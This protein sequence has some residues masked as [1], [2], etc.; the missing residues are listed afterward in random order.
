M[1][2]IKIDT[3]NR[4]K[5][6]IRKMKTTNFLVIFLVLIL[7]MIIIQAIP[8]EGQF[9]EEQEPGNLIKSE[10]W[11]EIQN[12]IRGS[13]E[14]HPG[15]TPDSW[16][17]GFKRF[18]EGIDLFFTFDEVT[19]AKKHLHYAGLRLSEAKTMV[20][21]EK[22]AYAQRLMNDYEKNI[23]GSNEIVTKAQSIGK[24]VTKITELVALATF[25]HLG[26]LEDVYEKVP[27]QAKPAINKAKNSSMNGQKN[28]LENLAKEKPKKALEL[29]LQIAEKRLEKARLKAEKGETKE[30]EEL[31]G[32]YEKI[33]KRNRYFYGKLFE[34][35]DFET[36]EIY[37]KTSRHLEIL[38]EVHEKVPKEFKSGI[39]RAMNVSMK[40][41]E[42]V[43]DVLGE[44]K[45]KRTAKL[46]FNLTEKRFLKLK[47]KAEKGEDVD[48][49]ARGYKRGINKSLKMIEKSESVDK[50]G[51]INMVEKVS[52]ATSKHLKILE[53][54]Y[55]KVPAQ[56]KK[57]IE[58]A[59]NFS[60]K[61][62]KNALIALSKEEPRKAADMTLDI[63]KGRLKK[64]KE[65][66]EERKNKD[67]EEAL[68][69]YEAMVE[70]SK[71]IAEKD[72]DAL[73][74]LASNF[75]EQLKSLDEI[76]DKLSGDVKVKVKEK[77]LASLEK[78][79]ETLGKLAK[80][81]PE[82]A[83][84]IFSKAAEIRLKRAN[85]K[86]AKNETEYAEDEIKEFEKLAKF[87]NEI[88]EIARGLGKDT[89]TVEQL[90]A[91]ATSH[92][93]EILNEVYEKVPEQAKEA[94]EKAMNVSVK[95][96][97][98]AVEALKRKDALGEIPEKIQVIEE[99]EEK[100][101]SIAKD[102]KS[103][104]PKEKLEVPEKPITTTT[105]IATTTTVKIPGKE[106][107]RTTI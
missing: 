76:E 77:K 47:E 19:K 24:N 31:M 88:S 106:K 86:A 35:R 26:V 99:I 3:Y 54:V 17:Y 39:K 63:I 12:E 2:L 23:K 16:I 44:I 36:E 14:K 65:K 80:E 97:E 5:N 34:R 48:D 90:V 55:E 85:E 95:G 83:A 30:V 66:A 101:P 87:G 37:H 25:V 84:D 89:T 6:G 18:F 58:K 107:T 75:N 1:N 71:E 105:I 92:H 32:D 67:V 49:L 73:E 8:T 7:S 21:K 57:G 82:K 40:G 15:I 104:V 29:N 68:K 28:A 53:E 79:R 20:E 33:M 93:L 62:Q 10:D 94:I 98:K 103:S 64:A 45:P 69:E 52:D 50:K 59:M 27:E 70:L 13:I 81:K 102:K 38:D 72:E 42:R 100:I 22:P 60:R 56:A 51:A 74:K 96:R 78:Q 41:Q 61:G 43:L 11:N 9:G 46:Y 4:G 91:K